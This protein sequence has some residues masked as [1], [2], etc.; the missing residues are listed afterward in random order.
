MQGSTATA[1]SEQTEPTALHTVL[2]VEDEPPVR[3]LLADV[4]RS[5]GYRVEEARDG[6]EA[7][8]ALDHYLSGSDHLCV[9]LLDMMLPQVDGI[10]V[11]RHLVERG[12]FVP[13]VAMSASREHL[14]AAVEAG[15]QIT[16]AKPFDL[17]GLLSVIERNCRC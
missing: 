10:G 9:V 15:A 2:L 11:L 12:V 6:A 7:I 13:V 5:E 3:E 17:D 1:P 16:V 4:L 8:R 14:A